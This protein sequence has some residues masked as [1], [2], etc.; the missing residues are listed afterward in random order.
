[1][2]ELSSLKHSEMAPRRLYENIKSH[3]HLL[4]VNTASDSALNA[5]EQ[6]LR[7]SDQ[8]GSSALYRTISQDGRSRRLARLMRHEVSRAPE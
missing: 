4:K 6:A 1:M 7:C 2:W 3:L 5:H 8:Q